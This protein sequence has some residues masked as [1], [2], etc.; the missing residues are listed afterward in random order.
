MNNRV[1]NLRVE[2]NNLGLDAIIIYNPENR[3]Y[4]SGFTG[5]T[6]Y[7]LITHTQSIFYTDFRY[8]T[9]SSSQCE[10]F[11]IV[12]I[13]KT[14]S[15]TDHLNKIN[16]KRLGFEDEFMNVS[17]FNKF[18][19]E[20]AGSDLIPIKDIITTLRS[21]KDENEIHC[22][23]MAAKITDEAFTHI[24]TYIKP[25]MKERDIEIELEYF[26]K[27]RGAEKG[28]FEFIVASGERSALPHGIASDKIIE[29]GDFLTL[30][31]GCIYNG[32]C[33]DMTR[34]VIVGKAN[35]K[36]KEIYNVVL[37]A[38]LEALKAIKPN[39]LGKEID[40]V[41][42]DIIEKEGY[43]ENFG[44]GLGHGVGLEIHELPNVNSIG[45]SPIKAGMVLTD[46]P[47]IYISGFGGV[48]IEDLVLVTEHGYRLLSNSCKDLI[49]LTF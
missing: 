27:K 2:M 37:K 16:I 23:E 31:F 19:E 49:E 45:T 10:G 20:L 22:I 28:S 35:E 25:G 11:E 5:S 7:V 41:A 39:A 36:Q 34:T 47:G 1:N 42:R 43:K 6:G 18:K 9:Q 15:V 46:E 38:Q 44:H 12:E 32:Y 21:V 30:D 48:R 24:L 33:S 29:I 4:I 17:T 8:L 26:M 40:K 3:R 13:S 14:V